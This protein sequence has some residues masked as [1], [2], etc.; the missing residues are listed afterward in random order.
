MLSNLSIPR[1][2]GFVFFQFPDASQICAE[3]EFG[4]FPFDTRSSREFAGVSR[5]FSSFP[6]THRWV[7]LSTPQNLHNTNSFTPFFLDSTTQ[8]YKRLS[9]CPS[10][11]CY[12]QKTITAVSV[13][14]SFCSVLRCLY[15]LVMSRCRGLDDSQLSMKLQ[16]VEE[17]RWNYLDTFDSLSIMYS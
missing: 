7:T 9:L 11:R 12:F 16:L 14:C 8:I 15:S 2:I 17:F 10:V 13:T 1:C 3:W 4:T 5:Y 6:I